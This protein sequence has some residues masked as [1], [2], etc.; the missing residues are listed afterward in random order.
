[1]DIELTAEQSDLVRRA[2]AMGRIA[3]PEEAVAEAMARWTE[4]ERQRTEFLAS[5]DEADA[6]FD[7]GDSLRIETEQDAR[8]L[9]A[10]IK[11]SYRTALAAEG[12]D[13]S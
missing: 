3:R 6:E 13:P 11:A 4:V 8:A 9:I 5:L 10:D 7:R 12:F 2:I 1:M